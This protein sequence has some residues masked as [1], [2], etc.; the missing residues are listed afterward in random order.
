[1]TEVA[2][3]EAPDGK[4]PAVVLKDIVIGQSLPLWAKAWS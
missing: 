4:D 2:E 3:F 1:M